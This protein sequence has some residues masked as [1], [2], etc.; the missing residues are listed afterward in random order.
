M[1]IDKTK[2]L[3]NGAAYDWAS[4]TISFGLAGLSD[5]VIYGV[6][7]ISYENDMPIVNNFGKGRLPVSWGRQ[8]I[9]ASAS[10]TLSTEEF[11]KLEDIAP[12]KVVQDLPKFDV[13]VFYETADGTTRQDIIRDCHLTKNG[14]S[15]SQNDPESKVEMELNPSFIDFGV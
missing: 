7:S 8:N 9:S 2:I 3:I 11:H 12:D 1:A 5:Q 10:L 13:I 6:S 15:L 14:R 4:I